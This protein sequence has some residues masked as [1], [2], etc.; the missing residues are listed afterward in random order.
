[1]GGKWQNV[2]LVKGKEDQGKAVLSIY[3]AA[4]DVLTTLH[5]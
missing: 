2:S 1:M 5:C 3:A 4:K